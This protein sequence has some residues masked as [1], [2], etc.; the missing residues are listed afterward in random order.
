MHDWEHRKIHAHPLL[1]KIRLGVVPAD[2]IKNLLLDNRIQEAPE[3]V[4]M[5]EDVL[6]LHATK[7]VL[8]VPPAHSHPEMFATRSTINVSVNL[9]FIITMWFKK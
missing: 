9:F 2:N 5:L 6:K 8:D 3:C 1:E 4:Q 7:E